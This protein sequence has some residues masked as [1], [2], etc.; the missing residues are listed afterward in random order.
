MQKHAKTHTDAPT[1]GQNRTTRTPGQNR[2]AHTKQAS[3]AKI[4]A[5]VKQSNLNN[6]RK[7]S[8]ARKRQ[9]RI[10]RQMPRQTYKDQGG[11]LAKLSQTNS[12]KPSQSK[13]RSKTKLKQR[14]NRLKQKTQQTNYILKWQNGL[15]VFLCFLLRASETPSKHVRTLAEDVRT[16]QKQKQKQKQSKSQA[17]Q[18]NAK[19]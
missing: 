19:P 9:R 2:T 16:K 1:P 10:Q 15:E 4:K 8:S 11:A 13:K 17:K 3:Q 6:K 14:A 12:A 7:Q 18:S 5:K